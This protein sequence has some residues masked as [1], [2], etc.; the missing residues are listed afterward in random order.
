M[1]KHFYA[2]LLAGFPWS[3]SAQIYVDPSTSAAMATQSVLINSQLNSTKEKLT[4]LQRAQLTVSGQLAIANDLQSRI[5][6]GLTEVSSA[7]NNLLAVKDIYEITQDIF[8]DGKKAISI[9]EKNPALL[10][11]AQQGAEEFHSR[12]LR[13]SAEVSGFVL[14][15]SKQ[16]LMDSGERTRM[17]GKIVTELSILRGV[18]YG[19]YRAMYWASIRGFWNAVN[20]YAGF[21]NVDKRIA[22]EVLFKSKLFKK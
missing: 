10:L 20:P 8:S 3:L 11:F 13:L 21:I 9:A 1:K 7:M 5:Y 18:I 17:L 2:F 15:G 19:I 22:D 4:L 6:R 14:H 12:A 16:N